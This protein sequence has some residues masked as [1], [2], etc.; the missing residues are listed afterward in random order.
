MTYDEKYLRGRFHR[1]LGDAGKLLAE[2][3]AQADV[4]NRADIGSLIV[5]AMRESLVEH[6]GFRTA[7]LPQLPEGRSEQATALNISELAC[8]RLAEDLSAARLRIK[9]L[10]TVALEA[11][12]YLEVL[13]SIATGKETR[14]LVWGLILRLRALLSSAQGETKEGFDGLPELP[15]GERDEPAVGTTAAL[16]G[17]PT[18]C[19]MR[20]RD[21]GKPYPRSGCQ[22]CERGGLR[23][24]PF[25]S[26]TW[27]A[28]HI[29]TPTLG[30]G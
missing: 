22:S 2:A 25:D 14:A 7:D 29:A 28:P 10:E 17:R 16:A 3:Y 18:N 30:E 26:T 27:R 12:P 5:T 1:L 19:R 23:G 8:E 6:Q 24:C 9:A 15:C 4:E 11:E 20:L 21:E 13:H